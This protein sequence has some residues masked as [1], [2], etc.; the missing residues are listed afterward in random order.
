MMEYNLF[1]IL[2]GFMAGFGIAYWMKGKI[3]AKKVKA[4]ERETA[5]IL[6]DAKRKSITLIKEA[7]LEVKDKLLKMK[8]EFDADT[9]ETRSELKKKERRI[10][11]KEESIDRKLDQFER[12]ER[13]IS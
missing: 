3:I 5:R 7:E 1:I 13:E 4:A 9:K 11:Q 10:I 6:D 12:R 8:A 2:I